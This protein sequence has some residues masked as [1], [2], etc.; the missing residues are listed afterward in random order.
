MK[1]SDYQKLEPKE[2]TFEE[3]NGEIESQRLKELYEIT[4]PNHPGA[5]FRR[6]FEDMRKKLSLDAK[7]KRTYFPDSNPEEENIN[8]NENAVKN[9]ENQKNLFN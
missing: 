6:F 4:E 1:E 7:I 3:I 5:K 8:N 2:K 9:I